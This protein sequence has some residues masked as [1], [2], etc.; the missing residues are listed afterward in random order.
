MIPRLRDYKINQKN[1]NRKD[2]D[3]NEFRR[4]NNK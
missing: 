3:Q 1:K 2:V 4:S